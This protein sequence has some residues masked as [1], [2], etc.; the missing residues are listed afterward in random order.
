MTRYPGLRAVVRTWAPKALVPVILEGALNRILVFPD[1]AL[2]LRFKDD[3]LFGP[4]E[5]YELHDGVHVVGDADL[6]AK[7]GESEDL[8]RATQEWAVPGDR[9]T[10]VERAGGVGSRRSRA[11]AGPRKGSLTETTQACP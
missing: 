2:V 1:G 11:A 3:G 7:R 8:V 10:L 5:A 9:L 6:P 4:V